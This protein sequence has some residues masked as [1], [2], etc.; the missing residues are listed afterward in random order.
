MSTPPFPHH[1]LT[2]EAKTLPFWR[3]LAAMPVGARGAKFEQ[4][5]E[6]GIGQLLE[7]ARTRG[8]LPR[9]FLGVGLAFEADDIGRLWETCRPDAS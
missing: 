3:P 4:R 9:G 2:A 8:H 6:F 7:E 1:G 5:L